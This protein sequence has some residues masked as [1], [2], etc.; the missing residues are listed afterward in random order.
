MLCGLLGRKLGHSYSPQIHASL[1]EYEYR[2]FEQEPE[3]LEAFLRDNN[4]TGLNVTIPYKKVVATLCDVLSPVAKRLGA[5]NT[6]IKDCDGKICGHNTDYFGFLSMVK[7]SGLSFNRKKVVVLGSGGASAT[8]VA[9]TEDLGGIPVIISRNGED[10]Y[11]NLHRHKD[12]AI[13]VNATPVGMYPNTGISPVDL[14]AFPHLEGVLDLIYNP[15][16]TKLLQDAFDRNLVAVNGLYMLVAQAKESA[17][18]FTEKTIDDGFIQE[19]YDKLRFCME[20]ILLIGMPGTGKTTI[21]HHLAKLLNRPYFD[22][23]IEIEKLAEKPIPE[24]FK[25]QGE[26]DFRKLETQVLTELCKKS[27]AIIATGG[28]C[29]TI[30]ENIPI[31]RQNSTII[32]LKRDLRLLPTE[33]RPLSQSTD[34]QK[35][36]EIR[37][38]LYEKTADIQINNDRSPEELANAIIRAISERT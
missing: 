19:I 35:M 11:Q 4:F 30:P 26:S 37:K 1:G 36:Y 8:V 20:N 24:I 6:I 7:K 18:W 2:L 10:N 15:A 13:L 23:D 25:E 9:V 31:L 33:G 38:P 12:A 5:V 16:R 27:G 14:D 34:L 28:G 3:A 22:S 29:V 21:G 32:W 17:E